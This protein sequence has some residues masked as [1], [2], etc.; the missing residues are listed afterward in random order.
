MEEVKKFPSIGDDQRHGSESPISKSENNKIVV[1]STSREVTPHY[2]LANVSS[3]FGT[4]DPGDI[5]AWM[6]H[7]CH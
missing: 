4:G 1:I 6:T 2:L 3:S 5:M 7:D